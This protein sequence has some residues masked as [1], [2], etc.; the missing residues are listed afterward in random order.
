V[1]LKQ[2]GHGHRD[3]SLEQLT[4]EVSDVEAIGWRRVYDMTYD[5]ESRAWVP[6]RRS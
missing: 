4:F 5:R 1:K 6:S 3:G 2:I